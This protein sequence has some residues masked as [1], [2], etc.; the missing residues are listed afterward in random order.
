MAKRHQTG[1][2]LLSQVRRCQELLL[3]RS[4][5]DEFYETV[6]LIV[7]KAMHDR[8]KLNIKLDFQL[9]QKILS[10]HESEVIRFVEGAASLT[11]PQ[12]VINECFSVLASTNFKELGF[13]A[14]DAAFEGM[15]SRH[16]KSDKG[17]YFTPRNVVELCI[18]V[19][20]PK[21]GDL[22]CDPAC[23]SAAFLQAAY[24]YLGSDSEPNTL[25]GFDISRRA[26]KTANLMSFLACGDKLT[27]EQVD[28]LSLSA[29]SLLQENER[30]IEEYMQGNIS[31]FNGFDVIA[32]NPPFAGD[33]SESDFAKHYEVAK[34]GNTKLERDV[35]FL[36][37]CL[38]LLRPGGRLAIV[39]PDN[40]ISSAK[41]S[42]IRRWL[43]E[44]AKIISVVSLHSH[45]FRPHTSQKAAVLFAEKRMREVSGA[46]KISMYRSD[47]SGKSSNGDQIFIKNR[48][49]DDLLEI[50]EDIGRSWHQ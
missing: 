30:T 19:L 45:T 41:F 7:A 46:E 35:L 22:I 32:T 23:G 21:S 39:L 4:G 47:K 50:S 6:R 3:A 20:K 12:D 9:A 1:P 5:V 8:E 24:R 29:S 16:Y 14:I 26:Q 11:A 28:S 36:E 34:I 25:Y 40:K 48:L 49:D 33:V 37:R 43:F 17:Q 10:E 27:I 42:S 18:S 31:N 13:E 44:R 38:Q 15:T 2:S